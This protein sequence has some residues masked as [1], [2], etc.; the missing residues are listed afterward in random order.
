MARD[1]LELLEVM[2]GAGQG[3][4]L[5]A[6]M[7]VEWSSGGGFGDERLIAWWSEWEA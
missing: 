4:L 7:W 5:C 6:G 1:G 3:V 2:D